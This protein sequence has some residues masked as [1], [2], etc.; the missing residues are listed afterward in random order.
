MNKRLYI[1]FLIKQLFQ[2]GKCQN[3]LSHGSKEY[4]IE[5]EKP[6]NN[7]S[8]AI[9]SCADIDATLAIVDKHDVV[10]FLTSKIP[11]KNCKSPKSLSLK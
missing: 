4:Y 6:V 8:G 11:R 2:V 3:F 5:I 9:D 1:F 7:L 10:K